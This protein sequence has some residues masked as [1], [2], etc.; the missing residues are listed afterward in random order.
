MTD[1]YDF[2]F[3]CVI[4]GD[5]GA[6]KTAIVV[7]FSQGFFKEHYKMTIG[8]EFAVKN[9]QVKAAEN[10]T[11]NVKLQIWDTGGQDRFQYVRPLYYKGAMGCIVLFDITN[12]ESFEHIPRWVEEIRK[13]AGK[14]PTLIV[15]NKSDLSLQRVVSRKEA[16]KFAK[17]LGFLYAESSAKSGAGV[18]DIFEILA[19]MMI[20]E[21]V[22]KELIEENLVKQLESSL[23]PVETSTSVP[24]PLGMSSS[25]KLTS[26]QFLNSQKQVISPKTSEKLA[27]ESGIS[28]EKSTKFEPSTVNPFKTSPLVSSKASPFKSLKNKPTQVEEPQKVSISEEKP[29]FEPIRRKTFPTAARHEKNSMDDELFIPKPPP[30]PFVPK[31]PI[32][33][34]KHVSVSGTKP[35]FHEEIIHGKSTT[36]ETLENSPFVKQTSDSGIN[37]IVP[38]EKQEVNPFL[39][40]KS[41]KIEPEKPQ[42]DSINFFIPDVPPKPSSKPKEQPV[43]HSSP[44]SLLNQSPIPKLSSIS[45]STPKSTSFS[46]QSNIKAENS[47]SNGSSKSFIPS[48][49]KPFTNPQS[50]S[51]H[52]EDISSNSAIP[53]VDSKPASTTVK[54]DN[55]LKPFIVGEEPSKQENDVNLNREMIEQNLQLKIQTKTFTGTTNPFLTP[56]ITAVPQV[57]KKHASNPLI[58][59]PDN[60]EPKQ[61]V[62]PNCGHVLPSKFKFCNKCGAQINK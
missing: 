3:K 43:K 39:A 60:S 19:L 42:V 30:N 47:A 34:K 24:K 50:I 13:E 41:E 54:I 31:K 21:E 38:F 32:P 49:P 56:K 26:P 61:V 29:I 18:G 33:A 4:L 51:T 53:F 1:N 48:T 58:K 12:R 7:R 8:V 46:T 37:T 59:K 20:G 28:P 23:K 36:A 35:N 57:P 62:C 10:H 40:I 14:I 44:T 11:Y 55:K 2:L 52:T 9:I 25:S 5:G 17:K 16:E 6:G 27:G 22:P 15:G 45:G